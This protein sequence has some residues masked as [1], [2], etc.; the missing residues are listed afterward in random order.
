MRQKESNA[1]CDDLRL[2]AVRQHEAPLWLWCGKTQCAYRPPLRGVK[3][4]PRPRC[5]LPG[6]D[7]PDLIHHLM[8]GSFWMERLMPN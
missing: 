5:D 2:A 6:R 3:A 4:E 8:G 7:L 1:F